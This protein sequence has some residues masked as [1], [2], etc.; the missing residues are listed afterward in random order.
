[1]KISIIIPVYNVENYLRECIDSVLAQT[2]NNF[3]II[4]INDGSTDSSL[5]ILNT[6][7]NEAKVIVKTIPNSGLSVARN[8]GLDLATGDLCAFLD[9]DD[10]LA[11]ETFQFCV[12]RFKQVDIQ[13]LM[14]GATAFADDDFTDVSAYDYKRGL[15]GIYNSH[16]LFVKFIQ[17]KK[18]ISSACCYMFKKGEFLGLYFEP[19]I[20]HEDN[21]YTTKLLLDKKSI[22]SVIENEF[23]HRR[24]RGNSIMTSKISE[25]NHHGYLKVA[26]GLL[27][28]YESIDNSVVKKS[29]KHFIVSMYIQAH[30]MKLTYDRSYGLKNKALYYCSV[31]CKHRTLIFSFNLFLSVFL[32]KVR[33]KLRKYIIK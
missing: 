7:K 27:Q 23:Y 29:L 6:Y 9:S 17:S 33:E 3:E 19:G 20:L 25:K 1:M 15:L 21:L 5:H 18:Y 10:W 11:P 24:V 32:P 12:N 22:V 2:Y 16:E 14:F 4:V 26:D 28:T 13:L 30:V 31:L 8:T